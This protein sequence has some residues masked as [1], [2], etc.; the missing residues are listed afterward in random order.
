MNKNSQPPSAWHYEETVA[1]L[2]TIAAEIESGQLSLAE[3]F[4]K[5]EI[6]VTYLQEC[7]AFLE[8]GKQRMNL[9]ITTL[10]ES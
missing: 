7:E 1:K 6:A 4:Q 5:F 10:P 9:L 8:K 3:V 2:E